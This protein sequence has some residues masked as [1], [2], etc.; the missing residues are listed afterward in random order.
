MMTIPLYK[1]ISHG[2]DGDFCVFPNSGELRQAQE[3][4]TLSGI[5]QGARA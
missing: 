5:K 3:Y 1:S 4:V 2:E